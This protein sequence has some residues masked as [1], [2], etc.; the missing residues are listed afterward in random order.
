[1]PNFFQW[2]DGK[3]V[4]GDGIYAGWAN[5]HPKEDMGCAYVSTPTLKGDRDKGL[6]WRSTMCE[7]QKNYVCGKKFVAGEDCPISNLPPNTVLDVSTCGKNLPGWRGTSC[8]LK[9]DTGYYPE[10]EK[11]IEIKTRQLKKIFDEFLL[12]LRFSFGDFYH[13]LALQD[14]VYFSKML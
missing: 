13:F 6:R 4:H 7:E 3:S 1:M 8:A 10:L 9:C 2:I 11:N 12:F 5:D 14:F